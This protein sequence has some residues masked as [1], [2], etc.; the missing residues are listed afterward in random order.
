[1]ATRVV[2]VDQCCVV[3]RG[4]GVHREQNCCQ[5]TTQISRPGGAGEAVPG[6]G[7]GLWRARL[8]SRLGHLS[9]CDLQQVTKLQSRH[10]KIGMVIHIPLK[11]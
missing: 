9:V 8:E 3:S 4:L 2:S 7:N 1:M 5:I 11:V 6:G 10:A